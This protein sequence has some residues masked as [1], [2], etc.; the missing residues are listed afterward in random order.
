[1][2]IIIY[3]VTVLMERTTRCKVGAM[4]AQ[5]SVSGRLQVHVNVHGRVGA[6]YTAAL[7]TLQQTQVCQD[8]HVFVY[9]LDIAPH[10]SGEF[11]HRQFTFALGGTNK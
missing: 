7:R 3:L 4:H 6:K 2:A 10:N 9:A 11:A 1:M 8:H 5:R